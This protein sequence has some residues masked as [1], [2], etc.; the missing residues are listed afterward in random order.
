M[1]I[2]YVHEPALRC[3]YATIRPN[4]KN[5]RRPLRERTYKP[6]AT[7]GEEENALLRKSLKYAARAIPTKPNRD[8]ERSQPVIFIE[9]PLK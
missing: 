4:Q 1:F 9:T 2:S 6:E 3:T 7:S 8:S 5:Y